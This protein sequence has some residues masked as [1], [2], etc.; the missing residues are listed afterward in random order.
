[1]LRS[2]TNACD[3]VIAGLEQQHRTGGEHFARMRSALDSGDR[4]VFAQH[5]RDFAQL[6]WAH[7]AAEERLVLPAASHHLLP[8]DW[9][10]IAEAFGANGDPRFGTGESFDVLANRL[11]NMAA[12]A[13]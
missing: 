4:D 12:V 9:R 13:S 8:E 10:E 5:V 3:M 2:R 7:M 1:L 11:I 6:Q